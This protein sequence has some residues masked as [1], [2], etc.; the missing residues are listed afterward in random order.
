MKKG[1]SLF[2]VIL[3]LF[4]F[5]LQKSA[6]AQIEVSVRSVAL[7]SC[8]VN[9]QD[10]WSLFQN[11]AGTAFLKNFSA[12]V[13]YKNNYLTKELS[14]QSFVANLPTKNRG[15]SSVG[16]SQFGYELYRQQDLLAGWS[17]LF[18]DKV[19]AGLAIH[20]AR[21]HLGEELGNSTLLK[22]RIGV[23]IKLTSSMQLGVVIDN[24]LRPKNN[25]IGEGR[26]AAGFYAGMKYQFSQ[27]LAS[28]LQAE[29]ISEQAPSFRLALEYCPIEHFFL[30]GGLASKPL[31]ESFGFGFVWRQIKVDISSAYHQHLGFSPALSMTY[32]F[33]NHE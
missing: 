12:G 1:H 2:R 14:H 18:S 3:Y 13:S 25:R 28:Y 24:P 9:L 32:D 5:C 16:Y 31:S 21:I 33:N 10:E 19:S 4:C 15:V 7:S 8:S 30:R 17:R 23:Q 11:P 22:C 27:K 20:Y 26:S 6:L 29:Q